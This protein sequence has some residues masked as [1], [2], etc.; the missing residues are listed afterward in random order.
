MGK[1]NRFEKLTLEGILNSGWFL[2]ATVGSEAIKARRELRMSPEGRADLDR[3]ED[4]LWEGAIGQGFLDSLRKVVG[5][6]PKDLPPASPIARVLDQ[7]EEGV[8]TAHELVCK[9]LDLLV[10]GRLVE[11]L[12]QGK[13]T[14]VQEFNP[15]AT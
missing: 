3:A 8:I 11:G 7:H 5:M 10:E 13:A 4:F 6:T 15:C 1:A 14:D 9:V 12:V 2:A